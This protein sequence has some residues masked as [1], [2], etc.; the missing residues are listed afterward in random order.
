MLAT[1]LLLLLIS[2]AVARLVTGDFRRSRDSRHTIAARE[3]ADLAAHRILRDWEALGAE[4]LAVGAST[5]ILPLAVGSG[6]RARS[7]VVRTTDHLFWSVGLGEA[8]DS[9]ANTLARRGAQLAVRLAVPDVALSAALTAR[10]S[11][12]L[13]GAS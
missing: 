7:H 4:T 5:G 9:L 1:L 10:D 3:A 12:T 2:T 6:A 13:A 11:V 8:G